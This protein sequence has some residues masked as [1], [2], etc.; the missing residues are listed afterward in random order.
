M[1][2]R[3]RIGWTGFDTRQ[4]A[5][6]ASPIQRIKRRAG[7]VQVKTIYLLR[8]AKSSWDHP[9]LTDHERP[10]AP[11]GEKAAPVMGRH[12]AA[13]GLVP[14]R[15]LCSTAVRARQTWEAVQPYLSPA[16]TV[17]FRRDIYNAEAA[18]LLQILRDLPEEVG[19]VMLLGHNPAMEELAQMLVGGGDVSARERLAAKYPTAA[20]AQIAADIDRWD[21][22]ANATGRLLRFDRPKDVA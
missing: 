15:V 9:D 5:R 16:P 7:E 3:P 17:A 21:A 11:R 1:T 8:H 22:L 6:Y 20:L 18:D 14:E 12:L 13:A 10:L 2:A 4:H 19:S